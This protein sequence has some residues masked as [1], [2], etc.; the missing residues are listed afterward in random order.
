MNTFQIH[1]D[2]GSLFNIGGSNT[3]PVVSKTNS[4]PFQCS[5]LLGNRHRALR[6]ARLTNAQIPLGFY[7][8]RSPYNTLT[9]TSTPY[10]V[11][12]GWYTLA[13]L[14]SA[15]SS[16]TSLTWT[17]NSNNTVTVALSSAT[18]V[19]PT[20]IS[21]PSLA[22]LLGF[23]NSQTLTGTIKSQNPAI[24][25]FDTYLNIW[26]E[27]IGQSSLEPSQITYKVP[28]N[29]V[30]NN[31]VYFNQNSNFSQEVNVTDRNA[32]VDRLNITVLD[33][34]GNIVDNNG[35]DWSFSLEVDADN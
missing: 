9:I 8:I 19:V 34:F 7:N 35:L 24:V 11:T 18:L 2:T 25:N 21:Y 28:L 22:Q 6:N 31:V 1:V 30:T 13:S 10:T 4:N 26:I 15:L 32:R 17:A 14:T 23:T 33:R 5:I 27:N 3:S 29:N 12:P 20:G 16:L